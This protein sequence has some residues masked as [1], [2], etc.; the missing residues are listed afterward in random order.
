MKLENYQKRGV[1]FWLD[2]PRTYFAIDMGLGKTIIALTALTKIKKPALVIAPLRTV[3]TTWPDEIKKWNLPLKYSI[4]HGPDKL[5]AI[6]RKADVYLTNYES[7]PFIYDTLV[8]LVQNKRPLPFSVCIIDEGSMIKSPSTQ[9]FKY[10]DA[11]RKVFPKYRT[12][13]SGT[14]APNSLLDLWAQY[15]FLND[16]KLF[17]KYYGTFRREH[18]SANEYN[19]FAYTIKPGAAKQIYKKIL[20]HTFR[21]DTK[22]YIKLPDIKYN[23]I[24]VDLPSKLKEQ[25]KTFKKDFI[26]QLGSITHEALNSATLSMKLRQFLQGFIYYDT[27]EFTPSGKPIRRASELHKVKLNTLQDLVKELNQPILCAVQFKH[28]L[29]M[30]RKIYSDV[31]II[32]GGTKN[33]LATRYIQQW[34]KGELPLL[35]CH[36]KS[37]AHGVNL[38]S[39]G[40]VIIWYSLTWSL[41]Q[42]QQFN[43]RLHR[44]GQK[45]AV[46]I[47]H[48]VIKDTIDD[49]VT[50]ILANKDMTQ[51]ALLDYLRDNTNY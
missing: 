8:F 39:G 12:I 23:Y 36:P 31:P 38:Q 25:Y 16:G 47:N 44:R 26:L 19:P 20:P 2:N 29:E 41:E 13:L 48:L 22:D 33:T 35:L 45:N 4:I 14:P 3:Y 30:I 27:G 7:I 24:S 15:Y 5:E 28:E 34:N 42:Y 1:R 50:R 43:K 40:C 32:A 49:R 11:L 37:L 6:A 51:Q 10:F 21:L 17:S 46:M 9:R 18:Y